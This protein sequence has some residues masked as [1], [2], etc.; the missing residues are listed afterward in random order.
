LA[1][2]AETL[3]GIECEVHVLPATNTRDKASE[4]HLY[5][6]AQE[7]INNAVKHG[8][9]RRLHLS[10]KQQHGWSVM[11]VCDDGS[12]FTAPPAGHTGMGLGLMNYRARMIG[13][14]LEVSRN[15]DRGTSVS[16]TW[17][18]WPRPTHL[19]NQNHVAAN[20]A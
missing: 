20:V 3:F 4:I 8:R 9:P 2:R 15:G 12:G 10:L 16:C 18:A 19:E 14:R 7:A 17:P 13:G 5:R 11:T 1:L 6:I